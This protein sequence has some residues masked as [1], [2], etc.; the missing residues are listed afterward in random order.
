MRLPG[1]ALPF[2]LAIPLSPF[3]LRRNIRYLVLSPVGGGLSE[4]ADDVE[5][6]VGVPPLISDQNRFKK[7]PICGC[8]TLPIHKEQQFGEL[9]DFRGLLLGF[10]QKS[11]GRTHLGRSGFFDSVEKKIGRA[12]GM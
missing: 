5:A 11:Q 3:H 6:D 4:E 1:T 7:L 9:Q 12:G 2:W 10:P 8:Q